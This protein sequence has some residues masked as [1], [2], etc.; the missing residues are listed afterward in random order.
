MIVGLTPNHRERIHRSICAAVERILRRGEVTLHIADDLTLN[1]HGRGEP[2]GRYDMDITLAEVVADWVA[3]YK[4]ARPMSDEEMRVI[5]L[6]RSG[7]TL[8]EIAAATGLTYA[9]VQATCATRI[10]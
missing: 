5:E 6:R 4:A 8:V 10:A 9:K 2:F 3:H 1:W 7:K